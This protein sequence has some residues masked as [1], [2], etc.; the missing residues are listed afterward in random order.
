ML[1]VSGPRAN[2]LILNRKV[3]GY[4]PK[5]ALYSSPARP[6]FASLLSGRLNS[7]ASSRQNVSSRLRAFIARPSCANARAHSTAVALKPRKLSQAQKDWIYEEHLEKPPVPK[8][9]VPPRFDWR[10]RATAQKEDMNVDEAKF[11]WR[12][13]YPVGPYDCGSFQAQVQAYKAR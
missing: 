11:K 6:P 12:H 5:L 10:K 9:V 8:N 3:T 7:E 13:T 2:P 1:C 4:S